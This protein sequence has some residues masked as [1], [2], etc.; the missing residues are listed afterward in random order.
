VRHYTLEY[1][2]LDGDV[3]IKHVS[4]SQV[5]A[6]ELIQKFASEGVSAKMYDLTPPQVDEAAAAVSSRNGIPRLAPTPT[7]CV[8]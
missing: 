6:L 3:V 5:Q 8:Q 2:D 7:G 1:V 4:M